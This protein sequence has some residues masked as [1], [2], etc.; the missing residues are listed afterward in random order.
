MD[1]LMRWS[2]V[3]GHGIGI[4]PLPQQISRILLPGAT[5]GPAAQPSAQEVR[6]ILEC[7][8]SAGTEATDGG[9][10]T[11]DSREIQEADVT[12][13]THCV[14]SQAL[15]RW[16][17]ELRSFYKWLYGVSAIKILVPRRYKPTVPSYIANVLPKA[18]S[19]GQM[20]VFSFICSGEVQLFAVTFL[21]R[22][23]IPL[24]HSPGQAM[25]TI[26]NYLHHLQ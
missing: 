24:L 17:T 1:R 22:P 2:Q 20:T 14:D 9:S 16:F 12:R 8:R 3:K 11:L 13:D 25:K 19:Q 5:P 15:E 7:R 21:S 18:V 6:T 26:P 4:W 10:K 23:V